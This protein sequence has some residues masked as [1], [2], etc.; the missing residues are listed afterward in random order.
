[1]YTY[2]ADLELMSNGR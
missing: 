1:V 2:G